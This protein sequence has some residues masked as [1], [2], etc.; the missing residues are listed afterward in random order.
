[1]V[2]REKNLQDAQI[3]LEYVLYRKR[4]PSIEQLFWLTWAKGKCSPFAEQLFR[5]DMVGM[6]RSALHPLYFLLLE[7]LNVGEYSPSIMF[8]SLP[9]ICNDGEHSLSFLSS[10]PFKAFTMIESTPYLK[11]LI[12]LC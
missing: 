7:H 8:P 9:S 12:F 1:V 4:S 6:M 5:T 11:I 3:W 2:D 10:F